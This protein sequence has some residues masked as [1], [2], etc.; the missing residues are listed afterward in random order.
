VMVLCALEG[1]VWLGGE[2]V[3]RERE[4]AR[5]SVRV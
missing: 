2:R 3:R 1:G 4:R 5:G